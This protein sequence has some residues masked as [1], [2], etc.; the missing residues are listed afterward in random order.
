[1][2]VGQRFKAGCG[3]PLRGRDFNCVRRCTDCCN[4]D[5]EAKHEPT[6]DELG[7]HD[8]STALV[9]KDQEGLSITWRLTSDEAMM[10]DP[11][12]MIAHPVKG[13]V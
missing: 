12:M 6:R 9:S 7:R 1:M 10:A 3:P 13:V 4:R 2:S 5:P 11:I 8:V